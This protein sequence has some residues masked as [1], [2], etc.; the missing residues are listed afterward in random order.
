MIMLRTYLLCAPVCPDWCVISHTHTRAH[1]AVLHCSDPFTALHD[2]SSGSFFLCG[3]SH[4]AGATPWTTT[5]PR[6]RSPTLR[7]VVQHGKLAQVTVLVQQS[8]ATERY[9]SGGCQ[10]EWLSSSGHRLRRRVFSSSQDVTSSH[11]NHGPSRE[12]A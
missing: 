9:R 10:V 8:S 11:V 3:F 5:L 2:S 6:A 1:A 12:F 4:V 7:S